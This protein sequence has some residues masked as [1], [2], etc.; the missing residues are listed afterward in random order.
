MTTVAPPTRL[1]VTVIFGTRPEAIKLAPVIATLSAD[2][3]FSV[4]VV[5]TGQHR[6]M[7]REII[8]HSAF[9]LMS[10]LT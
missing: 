8:V 9:S 4:R 1:G 5:S 6:E 3:R 7:V 10:I 2:G